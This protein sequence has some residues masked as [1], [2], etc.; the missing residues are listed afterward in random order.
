VNRPL[1]PGDRGNRNPDP[2]GPSDL[3][4]LC[5][6]LAGWSTELRILHNEQRRRAGTRQRD[7]GGIGGIG[8]IQPLME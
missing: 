4:G 7:G 8:G 1:P 5:L 3:Q 6:A 2:G